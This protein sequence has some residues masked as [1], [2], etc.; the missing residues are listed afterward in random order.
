MDKKLRLTGYAGLV[1]S[2]LMYAGDMLLYF[3]TQP[4]P[5]LEKDLLPSM[6]AVPLERLVAGGLAGPLAAVLYIIGFYHLFLRIK[7]TRKKNSRLD[8]CLSLHKYN[9]RRRLPC[10]FPCFRRRIVTRTS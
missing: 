7:E 4:L 3:T 1:G 9:Y 10:V 8:A 5:D 2:L 6:G